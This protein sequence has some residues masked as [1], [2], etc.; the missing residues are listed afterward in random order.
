MREPRWISFLVG[1]LLGG[2]A[3][4]LVSAWL[5][6]NTVQADYHHKI[7]QNAILLKANQ[8]YFDAWDICERASR[9]RRA[10]GLI[11]W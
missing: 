3:V 1:V 8:Y 6:V 5:Y 11:G 10:H 2:G 4:A 7:E 9:N